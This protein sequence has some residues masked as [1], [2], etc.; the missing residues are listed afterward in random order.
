MPANPYVIKVGPG[1]VPSALAVLRDPVSNAVKHGMAIFDTGAAFTVAS[2]TQFLSLFQGATIPAREIRTAS[3][4]AAWTSLGSRLLITV[5][6][7]RGPQKF[8]VS[9]EADVWPLAGLLPGA[10]GDVLIGCDVLRDVRLAFLGERTRRRPDGYSWAM[11]YPGEDWRE[12]AR[13]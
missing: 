6:L 4:P 7:P 5:T 8:D 9:F 2:Q 11:V 12:V 3:G 13:P 10:P 1:R